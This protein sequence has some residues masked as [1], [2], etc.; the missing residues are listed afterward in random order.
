MLSST[1]FIFVTLLPF[2]RAL[3][4]AIAGLIAELLAALLYRDQE[5]PLRDTKREYVTVH[6]QRLNTSAQDEFSKWAKLNRREDSLKSKIEEL[7]KAAHERR[8]TIKSKVSR[9]LS[10]GSRLVSAYVFFKYRK[11]P[12]FYLPRGYIPGVIGW[13]LSF[14]GSPRGSVSLMVWSSV[15]SY[16]LGDFK[17]AVDLYSART[18]ENTAKPA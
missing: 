18:N 12:V 3:I 6:R 10:I 5:A 9:S 7:S 16:M 17:S 15:M 13:F 2:I 1:L 4:P 14:G 8:E 11:E